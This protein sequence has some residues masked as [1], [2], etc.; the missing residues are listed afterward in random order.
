MINQ[1]LREE[2]TLREEEI[3]EDGEKNALLLT[4]RRLKSHQVCGFFEDYLCEAWGKTFA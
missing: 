3:K 4:A 2:L 1:H